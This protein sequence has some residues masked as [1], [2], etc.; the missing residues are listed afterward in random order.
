LDRILHITS[1][2]GGSAYT[3]NRAAIDNI[4]HNADDPQQWDFPSAAALLEELDKQYEVVN[5]KQEA[6]RALDSCYMRKKPFPNFLAEFKTLYTQ[7]HKTNKQKVNKFKKRVSD[8]IS[9]RF[10]AVFDKPSESDFDGWVKIASNIWE[11]QCS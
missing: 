4:L 8:E 10:V 11:G 2:L 5:I 1:L 3:T 6:Q 7:S 9:V